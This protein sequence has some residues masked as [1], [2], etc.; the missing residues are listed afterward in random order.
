M[1]SFDGASGYL[2]VNANEL[3]AVG[4]M[5]PQA[6]D[7]PER[8]RRGSKEGEYARFWDEHEMAMPEAALGNAQCR[9]REQGRDRLES[10]TWGL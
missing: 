1:A 9:G 10:T 5:E 2:F 3:G 6:A 8:Y 7:A 4:E